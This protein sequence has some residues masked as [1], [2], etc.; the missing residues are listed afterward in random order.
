LD[1]V[2]AWWLH[3]GLGFWLRRRLLPLALA[4]PPPPPLPLQLPLTLLVCWL[5]CEP[6]FAWN[7]FS[8]FHC[9]DSVSAR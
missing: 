9:T 6:D 1:K 4:P 3:C 5:S 8:A 2:I 7:R